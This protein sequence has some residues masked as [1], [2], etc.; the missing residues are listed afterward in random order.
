VVNRNYYWLIS[1]FLF[2][3]NLFSCNSR[4]KN[5]IIEDKYDELFK[6]LEE[7][8]EDIIKIGISKRVYYI[9]L[10]ED[11]FIEKH[12]QF[13]NNRLNYFLAI[14]VKNE[15]VKREYYDIHGKHLMVF[16]NNDLQTAF[17]ECIDDFDYYLFNMIVKK[18][19]DMEIP[20]DFIK[21]YKMD[22]RYMLRRNQEY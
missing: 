13:N 12:K 22:Y 15:N 1:F 4:D 2:C 3:S 11:N 10:K 19:P 8:R 18:Y 16:F 7:N 21:E 5:I 17:Y 9:S 20:L 14:L 6:Y